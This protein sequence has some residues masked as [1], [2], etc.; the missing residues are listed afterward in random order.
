MH[1]I[2]TQKL[3]LQWIIPTTH[4]K[5]FSMTYYLEYLHNA[6]IVYYASHFLL[7]MVELVVWILENINIFN[8]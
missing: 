3:R 1:P 8:W 6:N 7:I 2:S 4:N 5:I